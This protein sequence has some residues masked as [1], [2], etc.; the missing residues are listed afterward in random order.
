MLN[1]DRRHTA[2]ELKVK[3]KHK[4]ESTHIDIERLKVYIK[5]IEGVYALVV[6]LLN[7]I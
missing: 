6:F 1:T 7:A 2:I 3:T 4:E 5:S